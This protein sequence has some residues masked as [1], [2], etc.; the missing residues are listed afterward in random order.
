MYVN[1]PQN[2]AWYSAGKSID[3]PFVKRV[4]GEIHHSYILTADVSL[5]TVTTIPLQPLWPTRVSTTNISL[6]KVVAWLLSLLPFAWSERLHNRRGIQ[7]SALVGEVYYWREI[8]E[9]HGSR[10]NAESPFTMQAS[11]ANAAYWTNK[12]S[13]L[14]WKGANRFPSSVFTISSCLRL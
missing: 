7:E 12:I 13:Y 10:H 8:G 2:S 5:R 3:M 11:P 4:M 9:L 6:V 14:S 1:Q